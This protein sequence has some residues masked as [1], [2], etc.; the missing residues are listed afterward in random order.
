MSLRRLLFAVFATALLVAGPAFAADWIVTRLRGD[1]EML[2]ATGKWVPLRRGDLV[3]NERVV[4]TLANGHAELTRSRE[5]VTLGSNTAIS[6]RDDAEAGYTTVLQDFGRVEV[7]AEARRV[8]HFEV[9][10]PFLA[11]VVKGTHFIVTS[12]SDGATVAVDRGAVAVHSVA[13][14]R[15]TTIGVGQTAT[16]MRKSDLVVGGLGPWPPVLEPGVS[17]PQ[18][19]AALGGALNSP[20]GPAGNLPDRLAAPEPQGAQRAAG[21]Q[22]VAVSTANLFG[23]IATVQ[24]APAAAKAEAAQPVSL[25]VVVI[26][27]LLG[28]AIGALA[29]LVRRGI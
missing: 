4:R 11:A 6:I 27:A 7:D 25:S 21:G 17:P 16:V 20:P 9:Q 1:V 24:P 14:Q 5:V 12:D 28:A 29:L 10:T 23:G 2:D 15:S 19:A 22:L 18:I 3:A 26:G 8:K 13:T